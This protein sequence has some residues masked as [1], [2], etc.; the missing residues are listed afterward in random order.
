MNEITLSTVYNTTI[1][2]AVEVFNFL[3]AYCEF[4]VDN[5]MV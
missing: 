3:Y 1:D 2:V 4:C 5:H